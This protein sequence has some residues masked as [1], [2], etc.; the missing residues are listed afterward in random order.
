[1]RASELEVGLYYRGRRP[2]GRRVR[3][4]TRI[5]RARCWWKPAAAQR[6]KHGHRLTAGGSC[7]LKTFARWALAPHQ[8]DL[9]EEDLNAD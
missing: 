7:K 4:I 5:R 1:V 9:F 6:S 8:L 3:V 2:S